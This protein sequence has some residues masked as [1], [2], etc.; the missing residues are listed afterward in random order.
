MKRKIDL[1][2]GVAALL[3]AALLTAVASGDVPLGIPYE[4]VWPRLIGEP[5][6]VNLLIAATGVAAYGAFAAAGFRSLG[7]PG[8]RHR[9]EA[10]WLVGLMLGASALQAIVP[11]GAPG[12]YGL[13][14][15]GV[16]HVDRNSTGYYYV[17]KTEV[18]PDVWKFL[19]DYPRWAHEQGA[20]HQGVHPP[21]LIA[22]YSG[23]LALMERHS[24]AA[25]LLNAVMPPSTAAAFR[26]RETAYHESIPAAD[27]AALYLATLIA[28]L[29]CAGTVAP[30]YLLA[31]ESLPPQAAWAS[32][33]L[34]PLAPAANLFQPLSDVAY[35][36]LST[37]ALAAAAWSARLRA[38]PERGPWASWAALAVAS[39]A[40]M[41]F[42]MMFTLALL[43]VGLIVA[44]VV[45][46][47]R[48]LGP[49]RG[50]SVIVAIGAG[51]LGVVVACW[52]ATGVD[53]LATWAANL[54]NNSRFN[55]GTRR[56]YLTW[57]L[58]NPFETAIAAG[59]PAFV[60]AIVG[61]TAGRRLVPRAAWCTIAVLAIADLS[62]RNMGEVARLWLLFLPPLFLAA[63]VGLTRLNAG[64]QA[65]FA[66]I[67]LIGIQT[68][69]L[70]CMIQL[71]YSP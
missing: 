41:G 48:G 33:A 1:A 43:P 20:G 55:E 22:A 44:L 50:L 59:L 70:Q 21:G 38:E 42:G 40:V 68:L 60:W 8:P 47:K 57:L 23:L 24:G 17:V 10:V 13:S 9:R 46:T 65:V 63:G 45:L 11:I 52:L 12:K 39:G 61:L 62:G 51:F 27:R 53:L 32:A 18:E 3:T 16:I 37:T 54:V 35:P 28:L 15:W 58:Y 67:A 34:W 6:A 5:A 26:D 2:L 25:L 71:V 69:G 64:V 4:W 36:L 56:S 49:A 14:R 66:T 31:R 30:L 29:A 19:A 7:E